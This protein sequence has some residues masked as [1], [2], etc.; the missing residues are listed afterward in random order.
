[1]LSRASRLAVRLLRVAS[2]EDR[3]QYLVKK[4]PSVPENFIRFL[5]TCDPSGGKYLT[6][7]VSQGEK[8][9]IPIKDSQWLCDDIKRAIQFF[10]TVKRS[11]SIEKY[12][13]EM[14]E[15]PELP[16]DISRLK[17]IRDLLDTSTKYGEEVKGALNRE[18][19]MD[20]HIK[21]LYD[22]GTYK[23]ISFYMKN[24]RDYEDMIAAVCAYGAGKW[25]TQ[26]KEHAEEYLDEGGIFIVLKNG[27][28]LLQTNGMNEIKDVTN[29]NFDFSNYPDL[30]VILMKLGV[31]K[32]Y[33]DQ[34]ANQRKLD[35]L[36]YYFSLNYK[37]GPVY[38]YLREKRLI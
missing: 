25:C 37:S 3:I 24:P 11:K 4:F 21:I 6:Y 20:K 22:D 26:Y 15:L 16:D 36:G 2:L 10:M 18:K 35:S 19:S 13:R 31:I 28:S 34:Y 38:D 14:F 23:V 7:L 32:L 1:M 33:S 27:K 9:H 29:H 17:D 12:L 8:G 30:A 5:S